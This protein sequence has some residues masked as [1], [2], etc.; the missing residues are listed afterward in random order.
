MGDGL[1]EGKKI[2]ANRLGFIRRESEEWVASGFIEASQR[3]RIVASY[4]PGRRVLPTAAVLLGVLMIGLGLLNF[5]A[6]NWYQI[7][8]A[9]RVSLIVGLYLATL[10]GAFW[11]DTAD[12]ALVSETLLFFS[13]FV[14]LGGI[15]LISQTFHT[16]GH[17][18]RAL[19]FWMLAFLPTVLLFRS[20]GSLL[21]LH[22]VALCSMGSVLCLSFGG[23][24]GLSGAL[25]FSLE[26]ALV[27]SVLAAVTGWFYLVDGGGLRGARALSVAVSLGL[28]T[29]LTAVGVLFV[30][31]DLREITTPLFVYLGLGVAMR[32]F[33]RARGDRRRRFARA[34]RDR[35]LRHSADVSVRV[36]ALP[37]ERLRP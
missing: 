12:K 13:G 14:F 9:W 1:D 19:A 7:T 2:S 35:D 11:G 5:V 28:L 20:L 22:A 32:F 26:P 8:P 36:G 29:G 33:R 16:G 18:L 31:M 10:C 3:E 34:G 30:R 27:L 37:L 15:F 17:Y 24:Y 25:S 6:A 23:A 4:A 21:L